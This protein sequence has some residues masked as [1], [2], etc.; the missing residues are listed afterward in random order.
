M[1]VTLAAEACVRAASVASYPL[2]LE[3]P[4]KA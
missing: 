4:E 3:L 2:M 1:P